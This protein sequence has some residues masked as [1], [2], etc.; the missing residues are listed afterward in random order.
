MGGA[1]QAAVLPGGLH[2]RPTGLLSRAGVRT[3]TNLCSPA[4]CSP[5]ICSISANRSSLKGQAAH[6]R[7]L[8]STERALNEEAGTGQGPASYCSTTK[9]AAKT[10]Q[11]KNATH[12]PFLVL[13]AAIGIGL[14]TTILAPF[15]AV[16]IV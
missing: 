5:A 3:T 1:V 9:N 14:S 11:I 15:L 16:V 13:Y 10:P 2:R 8:N 6:S 4:I 7:P 12:R